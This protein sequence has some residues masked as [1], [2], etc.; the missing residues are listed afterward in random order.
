M[1]TVM[2]LMGVNT[3][4]NICNHRSRRLRT[5]VEAYDKR[6]RLAAS[7]WELTIRVPFDLKGSIDQTNHFEQVL[8][9][10]RTA[11]ELEPVI[12]PEQLVKSACLRK[13]HARGGPSPPQTS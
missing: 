2:Q 9:H 1:S 6:R 12:G 7:T 13:S 11:P 8:V 10:V 3:K 5:P 4:N